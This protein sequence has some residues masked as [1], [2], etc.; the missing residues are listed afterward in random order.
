[1]ETAMIRNKP[2]GATVYGIDLGKNLFHVVGTDPVGN[3]IQCVKFRR[4]T[5]LGFFLRWRG[6][7][8]CPIV[9][10]RT[11][12]DRADAYLVR[13]A[14]GDTGG[15]HRPGYATGSRRQIVGRLADGRALMSDNVRTLLGMAS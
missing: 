1:M 12:D 11:T 15:T 7:G 6:M 10:R 2:R 9:R 3:I 5:L 8:V 4:Q 13:A 14:D